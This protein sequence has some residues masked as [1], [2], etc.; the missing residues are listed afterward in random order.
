M[1]KTE[2]ENPI[3]TDNDSKSKVKKTRRSAKA[4][5]NNSSQPFTPKKFESYLLKIQKCIGGKKM[6]EAETLINQAEEEVK[7]SIANIR[8]INSG[9]KI[10]LGFFF[11]L[12]ELSLYSDY[13]QDDSSD[14][15]ILPYDYISLLSLKGQM[16]FLCE[17]TDE[18]KA[19][20][21]EA[22]QYNPVCTDLLF[23]EADIN[24]A[25]FNWFSYMMDLDR[26]YTFIHK[27]SD[28]KRYYRYLSVYY[29]EYE[30]NE[31]LSKLLNNLGDEKGTNSLYQKFLL[32]TDKEKKL[33]DDFHIPYDISKLVLDVLVKSLRESLAE[34]AIPQYKYFHSFLSQFRNDHTIMDLIDLN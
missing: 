33:L 13:F 26:L 16:N 15:V 6:M 17:K 8:K 24:R 18:A 12:M 25:Q 2:Q 20:L 5:T 19:C 10:S 28:F 4:E 3:I 30:N 27:E 22:L 11:S 9:K 31:T 7:K 34:N 23:L 32:L 14:I 29:T 1:K 21:H